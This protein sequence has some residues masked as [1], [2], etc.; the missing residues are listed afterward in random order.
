MATATK[1]S[2][3]IDGQYEWNVTYQRDGEL[4]AN[5]TWVSTEQEADALIAQITEGKD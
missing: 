4:I 2:V 1:R 5:S 3:Y